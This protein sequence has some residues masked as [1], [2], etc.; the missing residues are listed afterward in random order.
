MLFDRWDA[1]RG[2]LVQGPLKADARA[3]L[4]SVALWTY[5]S[6]DLGGGIPESR[7]RSRLLA[8]WKKLRYESAQQAEDAAEELLELWR[9]RAWVLSDVGTTRTGERIYKFTHQTFLE[10]FAAVQLVRTHPS[11]ARLW[12]VLCPHIRKGEWDIVSQVAIQVMDQGHAGACDRV[13]EAALRASESAGGFA[14]LNLVG[15]CARQVD[16]LLPTPQVTRATARAAVRMYLD[17]LPCVSVMPSYEEYT[18]EMA[19][20]LE[21]TAEDIQESVETIEVSPE[22]A[23]IP[24]LQ[25]VSLDDERGKYTRDEVIRY[26][27]ELLKDGNSR[28][29]SWAF[30]LGMSLEAL[31]HLCEDVV[32]TEVGN[33]EF[34]SMQ[35]RFISELT[36]LDQNDSHNLERWGSA[37]FWTRIVAARASWI[38]LSHVARTSGMNALVCVVEPFHHR[39]EDADAIRVV[40]SFA[41]DLVLSMIREE[42]SDDQLET[43]RVVAETARKSSF[44]VDADWMGRT[45]LCESIVMPYFRFAANAGEI[46]ELERTPG[47]RWVDGDADVGRQHFVYDGDSRFGAAVLLGAAIEFENDWSLVDESSDQ[48]ALLKLGPLQC[49]EPLFVMRIYRSWHVVDYSRAT[50]EAGL[51]ERLSDVLNA[52]AVGDIDFVEQPRMRR[53]W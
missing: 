34:S 21:W 40:T 22:D 11:P 1:S 27:L 15:F 44:S 46:V 3:A 50:E 12:K 7:L 25:L 53:R 16:T 43:L 37:N 13:F 29:S 30:L 26:C 5:Q 8:F 18:T 48:I 24:L 47:R 35:Q 20:P 9:G 39:A 4:Q 41:E 31:G 19:D 38:P 51:S 52:W 23:S 49:L 36:R 2:V 45:S 6:T 14:R 32:G 10:Y 33:D 42:C 17:L 28:V